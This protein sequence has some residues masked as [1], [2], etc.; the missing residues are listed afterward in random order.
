MNFEYPKSLIKQELQ[1]IQTTQLIDNKLILLIKEENNLKPIT[2]FFKCRDYFSDMIFY[3]QTVDYC[4]YL[5]KSIYGF[6]PRVEL[7]LNK[8]ILLGVLFKEK[9]NLEYLN[10]L[11]KDLTINNSILKKVL[12][13]NNEYLHI[14]KFDYKLLNNTIT[15]HFYTYLLRIICGLVQYNLNNISEYVNFVSGTLKANSTIIDYCLYDVIGGEFEP[16]NN[17][18]EKFKRALP[19]NLWNNKNKAI[20]FYKKIVE[21]NEFDF[22]YIHN[23]YFQYIHNQSGVVNAQL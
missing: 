1:L 6:N 11:E 8:E 3:N 23:Q 13:F 12:S 16:I 9:I 7:D 10:S 2:P 4:D 14:I 15:F 21:T 18:F 5:E 17:F 20:D 22:E 19:Y